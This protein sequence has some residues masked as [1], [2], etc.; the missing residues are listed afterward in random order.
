MTSI[1]FPSHWTTTWQSIK[2]YT[3]Q[4]ESHI[5]NGSRNQERH[6]KVWARE[7]SHLRAEILKSSTAGERGTV[8]VYRGGAEIQAHAGGLL[9]L[10]T[11]SF[12]LRSPRVTSVRGNPIT[13]MM[14]Q[15][16]M[17]V[18]QQY[19]QA[20]A[21]IVFGEPTVQDGRK[22]VLVTLTT[23]KTEFIRQ[24]DQIVRDMV[25]FDANNGLPLKVE[26]YEVPTQ[27]P[28]IRVIYRDLKLNVGVP[29]KVFN[30]HATA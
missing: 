19:Q 29:D 18:L 27:S 11:A 8:L 28:V 30:L 17:E 9:S 7:P 26:R 14:F 22:V 2:D 12:P 15:H 24:N 10:F 6:W 1:P 13:D 23:D 21:R 4:V 3:C 20:Q 5:C 25:W 16:L